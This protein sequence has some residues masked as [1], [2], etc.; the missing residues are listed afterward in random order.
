MIVAGYA[1]TIYDD[2]IEVADLSNPEKRAVI[3]NGEIIESLMSDEE[4]D[5]ALSYYLRNKE[6]L[7]EAA[8]A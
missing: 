2:Y 7:E 1:Y 8:S 5:V 6:I 3:Q 4:D